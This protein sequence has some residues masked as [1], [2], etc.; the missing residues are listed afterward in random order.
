MILN[1]NLNELLQNELL[2]N[3]NPLF[4]AFKKVFQIINFTGVF[5]TLNVRR[6]TNL[7]QSLL[8]KILKK[9]G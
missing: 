5:T 2:R 4:C 6:V 8:I 9:L 7:L 3:I 1:F